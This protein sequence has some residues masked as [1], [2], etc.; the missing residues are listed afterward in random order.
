MFKDWSSR[1]DENNYI[2][3]KEIIKNNLISKTYNKKSN[4]CCFSH[5]PK[6]GGTSI[7]A[8]LAKNFETTEL[9][10]VNAPDLNRFPDLLQ[11]KK[12]PPR[13][14]CGHH[15][16]HGLLYQLLPN[17]GLF[18]FTMLRDPV[19]R[20]ISYYNYIKGKSDH[21]LHDHS[22]NRNIIDFLHTKVS[23]ELHNG[24][25]KRFSGQL[26]QQET[27]H[28]RCLADAQQTLE[29]CF[30]LV[31]TT[32]LYDEGLLL[33]KNRLGLKDIFYERRNVSKRFTSREQL[34]QS[35]LDSISEMNEL[36]MQLFEHARKACQKMFDAEIGT[37]QLQQ[38]RS[39]QQQ[40][41]ELI[42]P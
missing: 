6:T 24:Q 15:P 14:I 41:L 37:A 4:I 9:L 26:H 42:T 5:V 39:K 19:S 40:W 34:T 7:E 38:F 3:N 8:I 10:H 17:T 18:H 27:N 28:H 16:M 1:G 20:V 30:S 21:P 25:A 31:L 11:L 13:L 32:C 23:P 33:L 2:T 29:D 12:R 36:D 22:Q 35:E